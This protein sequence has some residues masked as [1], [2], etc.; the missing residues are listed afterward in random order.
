MR[1]FLQSILP[2][3]RRDRS[4]IQRINALRAKFGRFR[5][6]DLRQTAQTKELIAL[7]AVTA[8]MADARPQGRVL[9]IRTKDPPVVF[10]SRNRFAARDCEAAGRSPIRQG[11]RSR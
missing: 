9:R 7:L 5:D 8:V 3:S 2:P 11:R 4:D 10:G 6:D 1:R